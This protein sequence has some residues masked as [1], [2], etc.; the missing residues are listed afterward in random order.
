MTPLTLVL[1]FSRQTLW[2]QGGMPKQNGQD[3]PHL[4]GAID[5]V[6][7]SNAVVQ[8]L[9][10]PEKLLEER[11]AAKGLKGCDSLMTAGCCR[12]ADC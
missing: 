9:R 4:A 2:C 7:G 12:G 6:P 11:W 5:E 8:R 10:T 1:G 3:D